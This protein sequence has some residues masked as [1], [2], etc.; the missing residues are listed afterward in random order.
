MAVDR[1][2]FFNAFTD[3]LRHLF[4]RPAIPFT[5]VA[6]GDSTVEGVGATHASRTYAHLVY[7]ELQHSFKRVTYT[8]LGKRGARIADVLTAQLERAIALKPDLI[9]ISIGANDVLHR[10]K[11][12]VFRAQLN[13]LLS[14]LQHKTHA[15][16]VLTNIPNFSLTRAVPRALKP[17]ANLRINQ[18]NDAILSIATL[19]KVTHIDTYHQSTIFAKSFP[20]A[21][22]GDN[23]HPSDFGYALWANTIVTAIHDKLVLLKLRK[24]TRLS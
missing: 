8:N 21:I 23:F 15:M 24:L 14:T 9:T 2:T 3:Q 12:K 10:T 13:D 4:R 18:Y 6:L 1:K 22:S 16:I 7:M 19:H 20:E 11:L 5:Y 17:V